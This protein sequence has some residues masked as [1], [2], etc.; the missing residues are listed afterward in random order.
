MDELEKLR[1]QAVAAVRSGVSQTQV[2]RSFGVSRKA[3]GSWVRSYRTGGE[4]AL[5]PQTRGRRAGE[6][7]ALSWPQQTRIL[8]VIAS[9]TPDDL[10]LPYLLWTRRAVTDLIRR[11]FGVSLAGS[12][13]DHYLIRWEL[14]R[15]EGVFTR[16]CDCPPG[17]LLVTWTHPRSATEAG[18][19]HA[20]VALSDRGLLHFLA[21]E[22]PFTPDALIEFR[23]RLRVQLSREVRLLA[24]EWP[25]AHAALT[26][27]WSN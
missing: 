15:R 8:T 22:R 23:R 21:G 20:L 1:R 7:L 4:P 11:E 17:A 13:I 26:G 2:A 10:G 25:D 18:H 27:C 6:R 16:W 5:R 24:R 9:G 3:V 19:G 12:T 14:I